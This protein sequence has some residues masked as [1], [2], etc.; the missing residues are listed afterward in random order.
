MCDPLCCRDIPDPSRK[1]IQNAVES[2]AKDQ[3]ASEFM[4]TDFERT[5]RMSA[6]LSKDLDSALF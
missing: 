1:G 5:E 6:D 4:A 2:E 3:N